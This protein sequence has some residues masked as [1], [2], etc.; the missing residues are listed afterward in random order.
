MNIASRIILIQTA[1]LLGAALGG[2]AGFFGLLLPCIALDPIMPGI[3]HLLWLCFG[4]V[5]AGALL[6]GVLGG[7]MIDRIARRVSPTL[8][9]GS[10]IALWTV[11]FAYTGFAG[12]IAGGFVAGMIWNAGSG[13]LGYLFTGFWMCISSAISFGFIDSTLVGGEHNVWPLIVGC[14][15]V[16]LLAIA[17]SSVLQDYQHRSD[18][19]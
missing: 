3:G 7:L 1:I 4:T 2:V 17:L 18:P 16:F 10:Q 8:K 11:R 9:G 13:V 15:L 19:N 5:P 14:W 6:G 12:Y